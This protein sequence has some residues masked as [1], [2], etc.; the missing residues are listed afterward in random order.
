MDR[1]QYCKGGEEMK[2]RIWLIKLLVGK[3]TVV[4]NVTIKGTIKLNP[5]DKGLINNVTADVIGFEEEKER[6]Y[7]EYIK[8][9]RITGCK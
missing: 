2:L 4:M 7:A 3:L 8:K 6:I 9:Q 5:G 1:V